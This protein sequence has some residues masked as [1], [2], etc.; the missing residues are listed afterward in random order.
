MS[1]QVRSAGN[2]LPLNVK[3]SLLVLRGGELISLGSKVGYAFTVG[4]RLMGRGT[5]TT[6]FPLV[7]STEP[8]RIKIS[9]SAVAI[10]TTISPFNIQP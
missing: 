7:D 2:V 10:V 5:L 8:R 3:S 6:L 9:E 4:I 1:H